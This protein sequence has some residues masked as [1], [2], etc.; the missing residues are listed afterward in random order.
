LQDERFDDMIL[1]AYKLVITLAV[2]AL[3]LFVII[4][5]LDKFDADILLAVKTSSHFIVLD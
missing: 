4:D 3:I 5:S 2:E 1:F